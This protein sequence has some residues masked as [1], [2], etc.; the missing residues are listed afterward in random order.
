[1]LAVA[2]VDEDAPSAILGIGL[3]SMGALKKPSW[4]GMKVN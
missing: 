1:M 4:K 2:G 3:N